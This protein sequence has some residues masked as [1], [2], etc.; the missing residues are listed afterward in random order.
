MAGAQALALGVRLGLDRR[1]LFDVI[2]ASSGASWIFTDRMARALEHDF[3]PR[4]R[5]RILAKDVQ[6]AIEMAE[7]AGIDVPMGGHALEV[8]RATVAAGLGDLDDAA[9]I[10]TLSPD[11]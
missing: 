3:A 2:N 9:V 6:L 8:F 1:M 5:T 10:K 7:A 11:F 4:A